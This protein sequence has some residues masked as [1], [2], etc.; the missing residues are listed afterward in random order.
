MSNNN[1]LKEYLKKVETNQDFIT[2]KTDGL[3]TITYYNDMRND[4][5]NTSKQKDIIYQKLNIII[6]LIKDKISNIAQS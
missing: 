5:N 4:Y 2:R 1:I 3:K 6:N